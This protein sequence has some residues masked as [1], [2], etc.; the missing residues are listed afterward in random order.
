MRKSACLDRQEKGI[1]TG[2]H[3]REMPS[4]CRDCPQG[5][6][7]KAELKKPVL[8]SP[9]SGALRRVDNAVA[10]GGKDQSKEDTIMRKRGMCNKCKKEK[11]IVARGMCKIC[12]DKWRGK[13]LRKHGS[14]SLAEIGMNYGEKVSVGEE[15]E[16]A[17]EAQD[18]IDM[19][20]SARSVESRPSGETW[21]IVDFEH[22]PELFEHLQQRAAQELRT[23]EQQALYFIRQALS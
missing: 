7:I 13:E 12:Y 4:E 14:Y 21:I 11:E 1:W 3:H 8:H 23:P 10:E 18:S 16:D 19:T 2:L 20:E 17:I 22:L 5:R 6:E 9:S 15:N